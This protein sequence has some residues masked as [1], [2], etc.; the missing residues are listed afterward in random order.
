MKITSPAPEGLVDQEDLGVHLGR[1][2]ER[3]PGVHAARIVFERQV[4]ELAEP[5]ELVDPLDPL[6]HLAGLDPEHRAVEQ[7]VVRSRT[8][9]G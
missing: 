7:D 3:Q 2:R 8:V 5:G 6:P 1:D 4:G 9:P